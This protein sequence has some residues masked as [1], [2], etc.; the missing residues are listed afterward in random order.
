LDWTLR[1]VGGSAGNWG[2]LR[3]YPGVNL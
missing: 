3:V 1:G 2:V